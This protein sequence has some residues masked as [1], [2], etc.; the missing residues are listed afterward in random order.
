MAVRASMSAL[1][2][3][4][5]QMTNL[6]GTRATIISDDDIQELLDEYRD[7]YRLAVLEPIDSILPGGK[8]EWKNWYT[9]VGGYWEAN[10]VFQSGHNWEYLVPTESDN[11]RG[12]WTFEEHQNSGVFITGFVYDVYASAADLCDRLSTAELHHFDSSD[13][14]SGMNF[15][16]SQVLQ[17]YQAM[18]TRYRAQAKVRYATMLRSDA[19]G[20]G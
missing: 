15:R 2:H 9:P 18:A 10:S 16:R 13:S 5:R 6:L 4:M 7:E 1:I 11:Q 17:N 20:Q 14:T 3:R 12:R 8:V 19:T